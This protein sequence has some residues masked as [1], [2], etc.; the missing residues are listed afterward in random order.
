M[1]ITDSG[2]V[3]LKLRVSAAINFRYYTHRSVIFWTYNSVQITFN[4]YIVQR[5]K[6]LLVVENLK[7]YKWQTFWTP[8]LFL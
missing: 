1:F 5:K 6:F 4:F 8:V 3:Y 7:S 2:G